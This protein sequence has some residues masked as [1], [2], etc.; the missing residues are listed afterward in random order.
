MLPGQSCLVSDGVCVQTIEHPGCVWDAKF[1]DNGDIVTACSDGVIRI[2]TVHQDRMADSLELESYTAQL[3]QYKRSR[4]Y[5]PS[6]S[7][8]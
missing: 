8:L 3:S 6:A 7:S 2:W 5:H 1:L 4:Y